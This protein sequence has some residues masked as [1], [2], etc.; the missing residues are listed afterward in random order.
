[1]LMLML[2]SMSMSMLI[3]INININNKIKMIIK[4][5]LIKREKIFS[6]LLGKRKTYNKNKIN[7]FLL[8]ILVFWRNLL[9]NYN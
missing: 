1:M 2:M 8:K 5:F 6:Q 7:K 3:L 9:R 4:I